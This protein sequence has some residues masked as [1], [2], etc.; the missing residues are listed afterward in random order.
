MHQKLLLRVIFARGSVA[1]DDPKDHTMIRPKTV[2]AVVINRVALTSSPPLTVRRY[3]IATVDR[4]SLTSSP[5]FPFDLH[6]HRSPSV[7]NLP[8]VQITFIKVLEKV[9]HGRGRN[10][11][12]LDDTYFELHEELLYSR[13]IKH[14]EG[15]LRKF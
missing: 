8:T 13:K 6:R 12:S 10:A 2:V 14:V 4:T 11:D 7:V 9:V 15:P 1:F 5:P 3:L